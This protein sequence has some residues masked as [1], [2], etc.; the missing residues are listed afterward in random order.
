MSLGAVVVTIV[1]VGGIA[2][3]LGRGRA[4]PSPILSVPLRITGSRDV[5]I[6]VEFALAALTENR[7]SDA[8][9]L[10]QRIFKEA[11]PTDAQAMVQSVARTWAAHSKLRPDVVKQAVGCVEFAAYAVADGNLDEALTFVN[12]AIEGCPQHAG[13]HP[14][15]ALLELGLR[16][17]IL[18]R[19]NRAS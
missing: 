15:L 6:V 3:W 8:R 12:Q 1:A 17:T 5:A 19:L 11:T 9:R 14:G 13:A 7:E 4:R 16:G 18:D 2:W 10:M